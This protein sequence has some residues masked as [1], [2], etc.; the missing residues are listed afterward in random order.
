MK[1]TARKVEKLLLTSYSKR[2]LKRLFSDL[3]TGGISIRSIT[4]NKYIRQSIARNRFK[5]PAN[6][7]DVMK[8]LHEDFDE[9]QKNMM[10]IIKLKVTSGVKFSM[11]VDEFTTL[12]GRRYFGVN[13]KDKTENITYKTGLI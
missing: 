2:L 6:E 3:A 11:T 1:I 9:K 13:L 10:D 7:S 5:L 12:I 8:L 4:R